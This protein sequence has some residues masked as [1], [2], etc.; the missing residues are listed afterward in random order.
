MPLHRNLQP[1]TAQVLSDTGY[2]QLQSGSPD[3]PPAATL[4]PSVVGQYSL[5]PS[6]PPTP[7][8]TSLRPPPLDR[9]I[10]ER[11]A[12]PTAA[13]MNTRTHPPSQLSPPQLSPTQPVGSSS[14]LGMHVPSC[15]PAPCPSFAPISSSGSTHQPPAIPTPLPGPLLVPSRGCCEGEAMG[16]PRAEATASAP[17]QTSLGNAVAARPHS[18]PRSIRAQAPMQPT[19]AMSAAATGDSERAEQGRVVASGGCSLIN[20]SSL[21]VDG[22]RVTPMSR[23]DVGSRGGGLGELRGSEN[24]ARVRGDLDALLDARRSTG[25]SPAPRERPLGRRSLN[26]HGILSKPNVQSQQTHLPP[27]GHR[28]QSI[29]I[30]KQP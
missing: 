25:G 8:S 14:L 19:R 10:I 3:D 29:H 15:I 20:S 7:E 22:R 17:T 4:G 30:P 12:S 11:S 21:G 23:I 6:M 9:S 28:P 2:Y 16:R 26:G 1:W 5:Q 13:H 24:I 27:V 18:T